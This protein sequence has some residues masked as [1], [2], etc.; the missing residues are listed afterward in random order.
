MIDGLLHNNAFRHTGTETKQ[1]SWTELLIDLKLY[2]DMDDRDHVQYLRERFVLG[3]SEWM[4]GN[5]GSKENSK[6]MFG[7]NDLQWQWI[8]S[9]MIEDGAWAVPPLRD[10]RGNLLKENHAPEL[11][12]RFAAHQLRCHIIVFDLQLK[13]IQF[14]SGNILKDDNVIF[15]S[16]L[17]LYAT[18]SHFQSV[19]QDD[20]DFFIEL[21]K[22]L[23]IENSMNPSENV[24]NSSEGYVIESNKKDGSAKRIRKQKQ[25]IT[26][27]EQNKLE[28]VYKND[29]RQD[30]L[31]N[32]P[33][34]KQV[35]N[36]T[37]RTRQADARK[38]LKNKKIEN[39][40]DNIKKADEREYMNDNK[41][42]RERE[43]CREENIRKDYY[44]KE[45]GNK[46][47]KK[48]KVE[49]RK[50]IEKEKDFTQEIKIEIGIDQS[51]NVSQMLSG[52]NRESLVNKTNKPDV[53]LSLITRLEEIKK[54]KR[55]DRSSGLQKEYKY[56]MQKR[57]REMAS[58][59]K[60]KRENEKNKISKADVRK[61]LERKEMENERERKRKANVRK[62][63]EIR[64]IENERE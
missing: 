8:W 31:T 52:K 54:I 61:D 55:R 32:D 27:P 24:S 25:D 12:I 28:N 5:C 33:E 26:V 13:R 64:E 47:L 30:K 14:C 41:V 6:L 3:A 49:P 51:E 21:S 15:D 37:E 38:D 34:K 36:E 23:E 22:Q 39:K 35:E 19:F 60:K 1:E 62:D 10:T 20:H 48:R 45:I 40:M 44:E 18:G 58:Q 29:L 17:I 9:S 63:L 42:E 56:L 57:N 16:P 7:Y 46:N 59:D 11:L 50:E 4:A 43:R 53:D 2:G